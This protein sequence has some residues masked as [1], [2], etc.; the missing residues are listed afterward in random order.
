MV[1][2]TRTMAGEG[3]RRVVRET[4]TK[5]GWFVRHE[6]WRVM[7]RGT[8]TKAGW[9]VRHEPWPW[10][11]RQNLKQIEFKSASVSAGPG[12]LKDIV[13]F[14]IRYR[15]AFFWWFRS[16]RKSLDN[17]CSCPGNMLVR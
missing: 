2:G 3:P 5:A 6:P 8:R 16:S 17:F 1:R 12:F 15:L 10:R 7:V 9:F 4:R 14:L 13:Q 11:G